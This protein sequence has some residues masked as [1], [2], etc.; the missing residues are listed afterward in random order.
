MDGRGERGNQRKEALQ[1][2]WGASPEHRPQQQAQVEGT[3]VEEYALAD[4]GVTAQVRA[5]HPAGLVQMR[6]GALDALAAHALQSLAA[7]SKNPPAIRVLHRLAVDVVLP[8]ASA[9]VR[10]GNVRPQA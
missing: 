1:G 3:G 7:V 5:A 6:E 8:P 10:L 9:A 2:P 4:V